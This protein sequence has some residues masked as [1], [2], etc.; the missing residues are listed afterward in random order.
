MVRCLPRRVTWTFP[1]REPAMTVEIEQW[2][3]G[4]GVW[5][6]GDGSLESSAGWSRAMVMG[7]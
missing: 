7:E 4:R 2:A 6:H 5:G 3:W 1:C